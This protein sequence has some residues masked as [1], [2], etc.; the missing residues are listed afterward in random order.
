[1]AQDRKE[2]GMDLSKTLS[3]D[4]IID[5]FMSFFIAGKDTTSI[6][7]TMMLYAIDKNPEWASKIR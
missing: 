5:E 6:L 2:K 1:L 4:E 7:I 3:D